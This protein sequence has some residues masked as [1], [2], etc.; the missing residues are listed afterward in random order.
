[1]LKR[2]PFYAEA[3]SDRELLERFSACDDGLFVELAAQLPGEWLAGPAPDEVRGRIA[4][5][6]TA[7]RDDCRVTVSRRLEA[8][9]AIPFQSPGQRLAQSRRNSAAFIEQYGKNS[10]G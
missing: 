3:P 8:L 4:R 5:V 9:K 6:L 7:L 2:H 1:L 10:H